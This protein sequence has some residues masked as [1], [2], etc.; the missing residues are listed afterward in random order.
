MAFPEPGLPSSGH[1]PRAAGDAGGDHLSSGDTDEMVNTR[2][3]P[4]GAGGLPSSSIHMRKFG[5][6]LAAR[7]KDPAIGG[8]R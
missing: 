1:E 7:K 2:S 6:P 5:S 3:G 4:I 8:A